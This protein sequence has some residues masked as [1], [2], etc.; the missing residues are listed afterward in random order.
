MP[1]CVMARGVMARCAEFRYAMLG[2]PCLSDYLYATINH[3][4]PLKTWISWHGSVNQWL[5]HFH[6][7]SGTHAAPMSQ[8]GHTEFTPSIA[9]VL[10]H[11]IFSPILSGL[12]FN[13]SY[14]I[15]HGLQ[16]HIFSQPRCML[17]FFKNLNNTYI[18][19][20]SIPT[21]V[22]LLIIIEPEYLS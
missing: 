7:Y 9:S 19:R 6:S 5:G 15:F 10:S 18:F 21:P 22:C 4:L 16:S 13:L 8:V 2:F 20:Y 12:L 14:S 3:F 11:F 1:M 17:K